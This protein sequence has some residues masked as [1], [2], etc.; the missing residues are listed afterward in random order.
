MRWA[1]GLNLGHAHGKGVI[2]PALNFIF[3][4]LTS[5]LT[6]Q[7]LTLLLE[8]MT[9]IYSESLEAIIPFTHIC[10]F[11]TGRAS[12]TKERISPKKES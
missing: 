6:D 12:M 9:L 5:P 8:E 3:Q 10:I 7:R 4:V 2:S 1:P 11:Q